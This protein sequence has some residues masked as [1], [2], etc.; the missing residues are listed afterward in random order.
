MDWVADGL[1]SREPFIHERDQIQDL[2]TWS[3]VEVSSQDLSRGGFQ[4]F[5]DPKGLASRSGGAAFLLNFPASPVSEL[6]SLAASRACC[7][8]PVGELVL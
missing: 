4:Y 8:E 6:K 5:M 7:P 3:Q 2:P 1:V